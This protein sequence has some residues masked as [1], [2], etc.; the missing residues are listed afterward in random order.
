MS[1]PVGGELFDPGA[2]NERTALAW[3]RTALALLAAALVG[4]RLLVSDGW[5][6]GLWAVVLVLPASAWVL[7]MA[8]RRYAKASAA[9]AGRTALPDGRLP[10]A[11]AAVTVGLGLMELQYLLTVA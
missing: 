2:Q 3:R 5:A 4:A 9:L 8:N 7:W 6:A 10:T 11:V 1:D